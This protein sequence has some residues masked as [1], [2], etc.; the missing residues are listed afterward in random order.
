MAAR[1]RVTL[2]LVLDGGRMLTREDKAQ[3]QQYV[4]LAASVRARRSR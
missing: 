1:F 3:L 4:A 2:P